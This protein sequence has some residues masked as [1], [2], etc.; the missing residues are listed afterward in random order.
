M[1]LSCVAVLFTQ[2]SLWFMIRGLIEKVTLT[3]ESSLSGC[4]L[5]TNTHTQMYVLRVHTHTCISYVF[6]NLSLEI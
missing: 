4:T 3:Y 2:I 6:N 5:G 1:T